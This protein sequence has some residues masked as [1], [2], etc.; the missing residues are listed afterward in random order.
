MAIPDYEGLMLPLL[1]AVADDHE[2]RMKDLVRGISGELG[3]PDEERQ[4]RLP[5]GQQTVIAIRVGWG[6]TYLLKAG[7][8]ESVRRGIIRVSQAG[9]SVLEHPPEAVTA[10]FLMQFPA[11]VEF[12]RFKSKSAD[13]IV[14]EQTNSAGQDATPEE[15]LE[16]AYHDLRTALADDLLEQ[17]KTS[18]PSFFNGWSSNFSLRWATVDQLTTL[19]KRLANRATRALMESS[20]RT[21]SDW[22]SCAS[23]QSAG[24]TIRSDGLSFRL[25]RAAWKRIAPRKVC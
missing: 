14:G 15:A 22:M 2:H 6:R 24:E 8:L 13:E 19:E 4:K 16:S 21:A 20:T 25:L 17:V 10:R 9:R 3:L 12:A 18:S 5:S 1:R 11:F 7:L 23:T